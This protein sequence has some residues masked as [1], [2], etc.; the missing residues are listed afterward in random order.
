MCNSDKYACKIMFC[1]LCVKIV[2][3]AQILKVGVFF[4]CGIDKA[5]GKKEWAGFENSSYSS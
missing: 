2:W 1:I 3:V 4:S 5:F